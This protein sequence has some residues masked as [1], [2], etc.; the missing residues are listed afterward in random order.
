M[1]LHNIKRSFYENY[2]VNYA[3]L[4][5]RYL[6]AILL[7][8]GL[9]VPAYFIGYS[10][11]N[12]NDLRN[13]LAINKS[14]VMYQ[15]FPDSFIGKIIRYCVTLCIDGIV[16][17]FIYIL[18]S[19]QPFSLPVYLIILFL[20]QYITVYQKIKYRPTYW[21]INFVMNLVAGIGLFIFFIDSSNNIYN[22]L[23]PFHT[24]VIVFTL[25]KTLQ[26]LVLSTTPYLFN[27]KITERI[28]YEEF[29]KHQ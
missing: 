23:T 21:E 3:L 2:I 19:R 29:I 22:S 11:A 10:I 28:Q 7:L 24:F 27:R 8:I 15:S 26:I 16:F 13:T 18:F 5:V 17:Y 6:V 20:S 14:T 25:F 4:L 12:I 9:E 1:I